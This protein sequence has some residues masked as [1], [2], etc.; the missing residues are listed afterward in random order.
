M[1]KQRTIIIIFFCLLMLPSCA[2]HYSSEIVDN[3]YGFFSGFW[4]GMICP[5]TIFI[6]I[7][8]WLLSLIGFSFLDNIQI[9]GRPN[10][11]FW[12]YVGFIIGLSSSGGGGVASNSD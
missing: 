10:T 3:P 2:T 9:I 5:L 8:S 6:N 1:S 12:Y 11:G 7:L 4:H